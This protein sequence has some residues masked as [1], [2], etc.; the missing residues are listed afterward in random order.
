MARNTERALEQAVAASKT[1][2]RDINRKEGQINVLERDV[3]TNQ[4]IYQTF[5][6]RVKET[7]ATAD[8]PQP[9][10]PGRRSGRSTGPARQAAEGADRPARRAARLVLAA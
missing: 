7:D 2:I 5:L 10:R 4:Q 8:F 9:D 6:A 3:A 1:D